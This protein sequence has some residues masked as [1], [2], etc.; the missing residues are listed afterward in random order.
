MDSD[1]FS[2]LPSVCKVLSNPKLMLPDDTSLEKLLDWFR[3]LMNQSDGQNIIR[4]Q[5]SLLLFL[6]SVTTCEAIDPPVFSFALKLTGLLAAKEDNFNL[7]EERGLLLCMFKPDTWHKL[8][9]WKNAT[10]RCGWLQGLWNMLQHQQAIDFFCKKGLIKLVICLQNDESL[11]IASLTNQVLAHFL[12]STMLSNNLESAEQS[13]SPVNADWTSVR[14]EVMSHVVKSLAS[15]KQAV[16]LSGL[17]LLA[18][19]LTQCRQP[20]K[21]MLWKYVLEPLEEQAALHDCALTQAVLAVLQAAAKSPLFIKPECRLEPLMEAMLYSRNTNTSVQCAALILQLENCPESLQRKATDILLLPLRFVTSSPLQSHG[22]DY[23]SPLENQLSQRNSCVS[24][25][26]QSLSSIADLVCKTL[27]DSVTVQLITS[28]VISLLRMCLGHHPSTLQ[29]D[30][31]SY[32]L[33]GCCKVQMSSLDVLGT[34]AVQ[35]NMDSISEALAVLLL[36]LQCPGVHAT[37]LKKAYQATLKWFSIYSSSPDLWK[38]VNHEL[39]PLLKKHVCDGRWEVRDSTLE[40]I[41]HLTI[42]L[43]G[44]SKYAEALRS[45][46]MISV[47]FTSLS[48]VEGYVRASA[49]AALG[50]ALTTTDLQLCSSQQEEAVTHLLTILTEDTDSFPRRAVV[51]AFKSWLKNPLTV[52]VLDHTL[53]SVLSLG[54]ND[55]DWEVKVHTLELADMLMNS[56]LNFCPYTVNTFQSSDRMCISQGLNRLMDL[57]LFDLL[58]KCLFEC[59]RPVSEE[60]CALL[61][62]LRTFTREMYT[63]GHNDLTLEISRYSWGKEILQRYHKKQQAE[64]SNCVKNEAQVS[65]CPDWPKK[66][67]LLKVLELLDLEEMQLILSLSSDHVMNSPQSVMEDILFAADQSEENVVDCY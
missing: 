20:L 60:A 23:D 10:V 57:G 22:S 19:A 46:D 65:Y 30:G 44:S 34:L 8:L 40:F 54:S 39:F 36:Y 32:H 21:E 53:C 49:V 25:L 62:K 42:T 4:H 29:E 41:M 11:F 6:H 66:M 14:T 47:L 33:I 63:A 67:G 28:S 13:C 26:I 35:E 61:I 52:T 56:S 17:R 38:I 50:E 7:L 2:L 48:D 45:S 24:L 37:V 64:E 55:F 59:D 15:E 27:L 3:E 31:T 16:V 1:C 12:N 51:K 18:V 5:S 58:L 43:R 9:L